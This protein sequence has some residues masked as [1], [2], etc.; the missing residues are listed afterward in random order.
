M[1]LFWAMFLPLERMWSLD[2][3]I[4]QRRES[5]VMHGDETPILSVASAAILLQMALMYLFSAIFK[6]NSDW[7]HGKAI[8]GTL[9]HDFYATPIGAFLLNFPRLLTGMTVGVFAL[10]WLAPLLLFFPKFTPWL[11][12]GI[13]AALFAMHVGI[14]I[15]LAV[16]LFS[17]VALAG[18][19][20][21]LPAQFWNCRPLARFSRPSMSAM[22]STAAKSRVTERPRFFYFAQAICVLLLIYLFAFNINKLPSRSQSQFAPEQWD[23][24]ATAC[25][26]GQKWNMFETIPSKDGWYIARAKLT[27]GS[28]VD[29]LRQGAA[30]DWQR[31][32]FP[33]GIY[34]NYRWRKVFREM[35]YN[36]ELGYQVF[37]APVAEFLCRN[38][39]AQQ[40]AADKQIVE[41]DFI[42]CM[43]ETQTRNSPTTEIVAEQLLHLNLNDS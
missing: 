18:L 3:W 7:L 30:V 9:S 28:D 31:P 42:Y 34:P 14:G 6:S 32:E 15:C 25:G 29:L 33:A 1:L 12:L 17:P 43:E 8:A 36:D 20:L 38:W 11:R 13:I 27:D 37:R 2:R 4:R 16:D 24:L 35:A 41:F 10:E 26:F 19:I 39:D 40:A 5:V 21:F 22:P 23:F